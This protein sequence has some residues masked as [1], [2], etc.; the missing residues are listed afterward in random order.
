[1]QRGDRCI[2]RIPSPSITVG[3]G[4]IVDAHPRRHRRFRSDVLQ[5]LQ[6][7]SHGTPADLLLQALGTGP[8]EWSAAVRHSG[9]DAQNAQAVWHELQRV[10]RALNLAGDATPDSNT[11]VM[12]T[13]HWRVLLDSLVATLR[14]YHERWPLRTGMRREELKSKLQLAAPRAF[15]AV[16]R[17]AE[18]EALIATSEVS[19]RLPGWTPQ[20]NA[21][22]QR[23]AELLLRQFHDAPFMPPPKA[24]WDTL[25]PELIAYLSDSGQIVRVNPDVL[26]AAEAYRK[27][28]EWTVHMLATSG[29]VTVAGLRDHFDTSRK[30]ALALLEH[31][32]ERKLTR[33]TGDVRV[34]Y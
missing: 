20:L 4:V 11:W 25:D 27:L 12:A 1:V 33:R 15:D 8:I 5:A 24:E 7:R 22:Q 32:D 14:A 23:Q 34:K 2:V 28:V 29:E 6:T 16:L 26:F 31:L 19:V 21:A 17:R 13:E 9:L 10:G 3:G 30:Y 18:A